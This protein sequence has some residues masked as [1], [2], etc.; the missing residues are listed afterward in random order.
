[1]TDSEKLDALA[2]ILF[3]IL[4]AHE[5]LRDSV[6]TEALQKLSEILDE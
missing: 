5:A 1:M 6:D 4:S 3:Q 2:T